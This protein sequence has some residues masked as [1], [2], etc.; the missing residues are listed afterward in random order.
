M[1]TKR[2]Q[3]EIP[4]SLNKNSSTKESETSFVNLL[5]TN[6]QLQTLVV[7]LS[8]EVSRLNLTSTCYQLTLKELFV[9]KEREIEI[10]TQKLET[11]ISQYKSQIEKL[12]HMNQLQN[13][14]INVLMEENNKKRKRDDKENIEPKKQKKFERCVV[15]KDVCMIMEENISEDDTEPNYF[16]TVTIDN[17]NQKKLVCFSDTFE[18]FSS[19]SQENNNFLRNLVNKLNVDSTIN[20]IKLSSSWNNRK[21]NRL[22]LTGQ[23]VLF[24]CNQ[25]INQTN[26]LYYSQIEDVLKI[27]KHLVVSFAE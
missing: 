16:Y 17:N 3:S 20:V 9:S 7:S 11:I 13:I 21:Q 6:K 1:N 8:N 26:D 25:I 2:P 23:G 10:K 22:F 15:E 12:K 14:K 19:L 18:W 27:V 4:L 24:I 5:T